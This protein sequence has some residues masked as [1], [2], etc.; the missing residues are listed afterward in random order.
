MK[1]NIDKKL[2]VQW[3]GS[4]RLNSQKSIAEKVPAP[5]TIV[6]FGEDY[7]HISTPQATTQLGGRVD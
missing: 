2:Q 4:T 7:D 6:N 5:S 1:V 3:E